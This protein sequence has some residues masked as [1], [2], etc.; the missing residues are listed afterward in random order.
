MGIVTGISHLYFETKSYA[1]TKEYWESL[2]G[3]LTLDLC[4]EGHNA[5]LFKVGDLTVMVK[6][7]EGS[8]CSGIFFAMKDGA[9]A[10]TALKKQAVKIRQDLHDSHWGTQLIEIE[11]VDGRGFHLESGHE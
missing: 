6:E 1:R 5:G 9:A 3:K 11:D 4:R 7:V 8:P 2:G 10:A